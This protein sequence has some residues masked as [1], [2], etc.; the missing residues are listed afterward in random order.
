MKE[1]IGGIG[2]RG[3]LKR[4][5]RKEA[6]MEHDIFVVIVGSSNGKRDCPIEVLLGYAN[7]GIIRGH[8]WKWYW[9]RHYWHVSLTEA[10][11]FEV[12]GRGFVHNSQ[13][14]E[15]MLDGASRGIIRGWLRVRLFQKLEDG[16]TKAL[17]VGIIIGGMISKSIFIRENK[18]RHWLFFSL[19][20][21]KSPW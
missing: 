14:M 9:Q 16:I 11:S 1:I 19:D 2:N 3:H 21:K 17:L 7:E 10:S 15:A 13:W 5:Y 4:H 18:W 8:H 20:D 12:I 6:F